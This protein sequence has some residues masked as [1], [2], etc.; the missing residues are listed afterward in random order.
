M[1]KKDCYEFIAFSTN[2]IVFFGKK[3]DGVQGFIHI[4]VGDNLS[5]RIE[6]K[7]QDNKNIEFFD[8]DLNQSF[9]I[10]IFDIN[11]SLY[12]PKEIEE[13]KND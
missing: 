9:F 10:K 2:T 13:T 12:I 3:S 6:I 11:T 1:Q 8:N 4:K 7:K 5:D